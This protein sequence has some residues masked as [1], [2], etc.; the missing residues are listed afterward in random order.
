MRPKVA[1]SF[2][3]GCVF[4][5]KILSSTFLKKRNSGPSSDKKGSEKKLSINAGVCHNVRLQI[6]I[7]LG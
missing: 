1:I 4:K 6:V 3:K 7:I 5:I 2:R